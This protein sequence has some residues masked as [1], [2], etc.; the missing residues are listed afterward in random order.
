MKLAIETNLYHSITQAIISQL[1]SLCKKII[2][3]WSWNK[4]FKKNVENHSNLIA[5]LKELPQEEIQLPVERIIID[6]DFLWNC[7]SI[8]RQ[9]MDKEIIIIIWKEIMLW[10]I[11]KRNLFIIKG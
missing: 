3:P 8:G 6:R 9:M 11:K 4:K 5:F 7:K 2:S 10:I 1:P